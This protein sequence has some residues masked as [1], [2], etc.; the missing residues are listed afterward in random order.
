MLCLLVLTVRLDIPNIDGHDACCATPR[1][2]LTN[3]E[4]WAWNLESAG[5]RSCWRRGDVEGDQRRCGGGFKR[6]INRNQPRPK[7]VRAGNETWQPNACDGW[8]RGVRVPRY[9]DT[10][11]DAMTHPKGISPRREHRGAGEAATYV[12]VAQLG[13]W[14]GWWIHHWQ[15]HNTRPALPCLCLEAP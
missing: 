11:D 2:C 14:R 15:R 12:P 4:R 8:R 9:D 13:H 6:E 1:G 10:S 7:T 3:E 5:C